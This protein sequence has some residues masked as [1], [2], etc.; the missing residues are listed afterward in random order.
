VRKEVNW[1][2]IMKMKEPKSYNTRETKGENTNEEITKWK[3]E[4]NESGKV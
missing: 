1:T 4:K 3:K 2:N